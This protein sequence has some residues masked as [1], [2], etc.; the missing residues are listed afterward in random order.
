MRL[1]GKDSAVRHPGVVAALG[2]ALLFGAGTPLAK[3]LLADVSPWMLAGLLYLGAGLGLLIWRLARRAPRVR[4]PKRE[5]PWLAAAIVCGGMLAPLLLMVGLTGMPAT[6]ASLLLNAE[7]VFTVALAWVVFKENVDR[8]VAV[9]VVAIVAGALVLSWPGQAQFAGIWPAAAIVGACFLWA[10]DNNL[11]RRVSFADST[12]IAMAKGLVAGT[13]NLALA[14]VAGSRLPSVT[15]IAA[16]LI[17]GFFAYGASLALFVVALRLLGTARTGAYFSVAPFFGAILA[18]VLLGEDLTPQL[19]LAGGLMALGVWMHLI[20]KHRHRHTH[21]ELVHS[22][23]HDHQ[24]SH[25]VEAVDVNDDSGAHPLTHRHVETTHDHPHYPD[26]HH[27]HD[28]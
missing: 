19:L 27:R 18:V 8:R 3:A 14:L 16:A 26:L 10:V 9:G 11:T 17:V 1:V 25:H 15:V 13:A 12:W 7:G 22:H 20:E 21:A 5:I 6:G 28:H 24:D 23:P 4:L 2:S